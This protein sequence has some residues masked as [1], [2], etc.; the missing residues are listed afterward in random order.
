MGYLNLDEVEERIVNEYYSKLSTGLSKKD[1]LVFS[2][3]WRSGFNEGH[4]R[5]LKDAFVG[6]DQNKDVYVSEVPKN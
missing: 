2:S 3:L 6:Y 1:L 5:G 4:R